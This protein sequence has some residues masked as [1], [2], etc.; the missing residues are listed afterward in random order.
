VLAFAP[1]TLAYAGAW[2]TAGGHTTYFGNPG[3]IGVDPR[4]SVYVA[5][6]GY[7]RIV[8]LWGDGTYL[9]ELGG[10]ADHGGAQLSGAG[11]VVVAP[12]SGQIY[13]A[14]RN[15]NRVLVYSSAGNV[16]ARWG[17]GEG[18]G[19]SGSGPG[20]FDHPAALAL[21][22]A[23]DVYVADTNNNRVVK[24]SP[25]GGQ[26]AEWGSR[27]ATDGHF[28]FPTG[29]AVD[30][31]GEVYVVDSENNR[32]QI[33]D[34]NGRFLGRWGLRGVGVGEFSQPTAATVDCNGDVYVA[35]TNNNRVERFDPVNPAVTGCEPPGAWP[36]P[37]DVAPTVGVSLPR[38]AG[39]LARRALALTV[40]CKRGCKILV[41]AALSPAGRRGA[42]KLVA[43]ARSLPAALPGHVRLRVSAAALRRLR[44]E[45]RRHT[46]MTARVRIVAIGPTGRRTI[47][48]RAYTVTR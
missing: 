10:P 6:P 7:E 48:T 8:R 25:G 37:L 44:S 29:V 46:V 27:G 38:P 41:T 15:H 17:A 33:F 47:V 1:G 28:R 19:A 30:G 26:T 4:G 3:G 9:S 45:L 13:V 42:V 18:D 11:S 24:L 39:I 2:T 32:V 23:G 35:D 16:I 14:D 31:A 12:A 34:P 36:P 21:D 22:G 43:E 20:Q 40:S 5:D